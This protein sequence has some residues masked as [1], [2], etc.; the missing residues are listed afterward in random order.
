MAENLNL[1]WFKLANYDQFKTMSL[2]EWGQQI[3]VRRSIYLTELDRPEYCDYASECDFD[4]QEECLLSRATELKSGV[5]INIPSHFSFH[6]EKIVDAI[7]NGYSF[8]TASVNSLSSSDLLGMA[9]N[10]SLNPVWNA[11]KNMQGDFFS[12]EDPD[13]N[14]QKIANTPH[15]FNILTH[16]NYESKAHKAHVVINLLAS[17]DQIKKDFKHWLT[18]YRATLNIFN[19]EEKYIPYTKQKFFS[20]TLTNYWL[21][22]NVIPYIDLILIAKI[23]RKKKPTFE[24][25]GKLL[26]PS[27][28]DI[29]LEGRVR[30]VTQVAANQLLSKDEISIPLIAEQISMIKKQLQKKRDEM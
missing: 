6:R 16:S 1:E 5:L 13:D 26:F 15:D 22:F 27:E 21:E 11:C 8:A 4:E 28:F 14:Y 10:Q 2:E 12:K 25:M 24:E 18:N 3:E 29:E 9:N 7:M 19:H 23:E 20:K 30:Q 17:D